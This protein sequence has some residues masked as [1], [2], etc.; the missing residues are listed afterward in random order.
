M[1]VRSA[2]L[3]LIVL[4]S[5]V[6]LVWMWSGVIYADPGDPN[7]VSPAVPWDRLHFSLSLISV[8]ILQILFAWI[9]RPLAVR[10]GPSANMPAM[11]NSITSCCPTIILASV[12]FICSTA[13]LNLPRSVLCSNISSSISLSGLR[14]KFFYQLVQYNQL[15]VV[16]FALLAYVIDMIYQFDCKGFTYTSFI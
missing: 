8:L 16:H 14:I 5:A 4:I 12:A 11:I 6:I 13:V 2:L 10:D 1:N 7:V 15:V 3:A 9:A